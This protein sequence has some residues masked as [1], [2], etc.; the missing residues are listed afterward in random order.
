MKRM[1]SYGLELFLTNKILE[2][3]KKGLIIFFSTFNKN[4]D[5]FPVSLGLLE[6]CPGTPLRHQLI[7]HSMLVYRGKFSASRG[8]AGVSSG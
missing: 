1:V 4:R 6:I 8:F 5:K 3:N 2:F 7:P